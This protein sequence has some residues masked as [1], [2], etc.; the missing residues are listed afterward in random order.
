MP[1]YTLRDNKTGTEWDVN[2]SFDELQT[3]L[4]E[5]TD[6]SRVLKPNHF[7]TMHGSIHSRTDT[8]FRSH[9]KSIKKKY[10]GNTID[11]S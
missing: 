9:L 5:L 7:I 3:I 6:T 4:D 11:N 8:D 10:P 1:V 2:C